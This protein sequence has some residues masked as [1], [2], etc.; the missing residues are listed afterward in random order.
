MS[1]WCV[2]ARQTCPHPPVWWGLSRFLG[3][4]G[5]SREDPSEERRPGVG[6]QRRGWEPIL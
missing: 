4:G 2:L 3:E 1:V 5:G 6:A